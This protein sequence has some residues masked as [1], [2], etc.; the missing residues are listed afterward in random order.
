MIEIAQDLAS[1]GA[2]DLFSVSGGSGASRLATGYFVP[3][4][5]LPEGCLLYTSPSPRDS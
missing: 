5:A 1:T 4:D 3:P 2:V